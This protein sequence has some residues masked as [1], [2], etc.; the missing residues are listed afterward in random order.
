MDGIML[1]AGLSLL[2]TALFMRSAGSRGSNLN[3][4]R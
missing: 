3:Q 2:W 4:S 1:A